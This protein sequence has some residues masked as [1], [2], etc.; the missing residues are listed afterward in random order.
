MYS[1]KPILKRWIPRGM[2]QPVSDAYWYWHN[3]GRHRLAAAASPR[4]ALSKRQLASYADRHRGERCFV[5]GNGPSLNQTDLTKLRDEFTFGANRIYLLFDEL[6]FS[7]SWLVAINTLVIQQCA[8]EISALNIPKFMTW[9]G[10]RWLSDDPGVI[11]LDTDYTQ[12]A[13]F[14]KSLTDRVF[15][16][17]T[18]TYVALQ[19]AYYMGFRQV[20]LVGVDHNYSSAGDPNST[21]V[22]KGPDQNHFD[23]RYF[24]EG[25]KWQLPDLQASERAYELAKQA[26]KA[27]GRTIVDAT[28]DG[29]LSIFPKVDYD[30]LFNE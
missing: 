23:P 12:P 17:G 13:T 11:Y 30:S 28:M 24:G 29:K 6:G 1:L 18:V 16:G 10:R 22:S 3:R 8:A 20:V 7:T 14:S 27:D 2:W 25:F 5:L 21:V 19:L 4:W 15:E 9:R 26:F